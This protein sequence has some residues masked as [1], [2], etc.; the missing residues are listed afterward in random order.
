MPQQYNTDLSHSNE[1]YKVRDSCH[2]GNDKI[3]SF[4]IT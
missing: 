4:D 3:M 2:Q 1:K